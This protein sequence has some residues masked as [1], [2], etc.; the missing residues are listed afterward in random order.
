MATNSTLASRAG[1]TAHLFDPRGGGRMRDYTEDFKLDF[2][3]SEDDHIRVLG[4]NCAGYTAHLFDP[5][6]RGRMRGVNWRSGDDTW[7]DAIANFADDHQPPQGEPL[8]L[9]YA[10][11]TIRSPNLRAKEEAVDQTKSSGDASDAVV[12]TK[13]NA[14]DQAEKAFADQHRQPFPELRPDE[15]QSAPPPS[16]ESSCSKWQI[17]QIVSHVHRVAAI[18]AFDIVLHPSFQHV[19]TLKKRRRGPRS[20]RTPFPHARWNEWF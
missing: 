5:R 17:Q 11:I 9:H 13:Q 1:H 19:Q 20:I 8:A 16:H 7:C 15:L 18:S 4:V 3:E 6:G 14:V 10:G 12:L 2:G